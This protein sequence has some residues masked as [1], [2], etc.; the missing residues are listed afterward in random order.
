MKILKCPKCGSEDLVRDA[1][2]KWDPVAGEWSLAGLLDDISCN[3]CG[4]DDIEAVEQEVQ[5]PTIQSLEDQKFDNG[6]HLDATF[7]NRS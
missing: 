3:N 1:L 4:A 6:D 7:K 2:T 5:D